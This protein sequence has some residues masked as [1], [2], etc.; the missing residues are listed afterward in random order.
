MPKDDKP[1]MNKNKRGKVNGHGV[2][3]R[4]LLKWV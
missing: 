1:D 3:S 4:F 2:S